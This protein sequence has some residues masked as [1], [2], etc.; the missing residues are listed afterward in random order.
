MKKPSSRIRAEIS[1]LQEE[2]KQAETKEA[3]RI[4]RLA[5]K[6]GL[7]EISIDGTDLQAA[8][9]TLA[10]RFRAG[11]LGSTGAESGQATRTSHQ[12]TPLTSGA[13][14]GEVPEA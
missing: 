2:L 5:L 3:E 6:A 14:A 13:S 11:K 1:R 7:G 8:F 4:G 9:E 12:T 10:G